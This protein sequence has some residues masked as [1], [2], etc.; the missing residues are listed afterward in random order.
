MVRATE[1]EVHLGAA[2]EHGEAMATVGGRHFC[3]L[4]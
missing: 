1:V 4:Q 3:S 2:L